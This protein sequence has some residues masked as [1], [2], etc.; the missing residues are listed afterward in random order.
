MF[1]NGPLEINPEQELEELKGESFFVFC[2]NWWSA[3]YYKTTSTMGRGWCYLQSLP[4]SLQGAKP[5]KLM[6]FSTKIVIEALS[7]HVFPCFLIFPFFLKSLGWAVIENILR[8]VKKPK[9]LQIKRWVIFHP[10]DA[11][12]ICPYRKICDLLLALLECRGGEG[13]CIW[14][15]ISSS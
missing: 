2:A 4:K 13:T 9:N 1:V 6:L 10:K 12:F 8:Y 3:V 7:E 11:N 14:S 5:P 15:W